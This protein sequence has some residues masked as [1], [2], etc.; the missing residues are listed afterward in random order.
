VLVELGEVRPFSDVAGRHAVRLAN[1]PQ[2]RKDL[3]QRLQD[4]GCAVDLSGNDW[5]T[6]GDFTPP[7]AP[8]GG[9]PLGRRVPSAAPRGVSLDA[10]Y[11]RRGGGSDRLE[12]INRGSE[13]V[14]DVNVEVP[15]MR[16]LQVHSEDLPKE[17]LPAG[18]SFHLM[19]L[20]TMGAAKDSFDVVITGRTATGVPIREEAFVDTV[21]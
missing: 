4:A 10:R 5:L 12:I 6:T 14:Y 15:E 3:A 9:L 19:V 17:R 13:A 20:R 2:K 11:H 18:K 1:D 16:G 7:P 8:G 21:G